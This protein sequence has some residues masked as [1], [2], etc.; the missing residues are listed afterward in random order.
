M[1][2]ELRGAA[3]DIAFIGQ[4][5]TVRHALKDTLAATYTFTQADTYVRVVVNS[6]QTTLFL[7]PVIRWN[8][9]TL[10]APAATVNAAWTWLQRG[11]IALAC[12]A[13]LIRVRARRT[14]A[15]V[16]AARALARR[17]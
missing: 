4:D 15:A 12:V 11:G 2:V 13:L 1:R 3:S 14:E 9:T 10:P 7:N 17:A 6:P 5:G 8:G 16:P